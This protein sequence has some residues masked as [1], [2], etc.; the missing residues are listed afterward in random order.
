MAQIV[1]VNEEGGLYLPSELLAQLLGNA[2]PHARYV[3]KAQDGNLI[4][5]RFDQM[6]PFWATAS[7]T[8]RA[9]AFHDW[10]MSHKDGPG[11]PDEALRRENIYD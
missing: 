5:I 4:L 2:Q 9:K 10:A 7:P 11:L 1:E 3:L 8:E 6:Q